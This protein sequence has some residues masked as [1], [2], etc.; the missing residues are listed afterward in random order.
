[1]TAIPAP[2]RIVRV[3]EEAGQGP[4]GLEGLDQPAAESCPG[5]VAVAV[6]VAAA[7]TVD[8]GAG[9]RRSYSVLFVDP[10]VDVVSQ[11]VSQ[12]AGPGWVGAVQVGGIGL[13]TETVPKPPSG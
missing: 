3:V 12:V 10:L 6:V 7:V 1:M 2:R 5:A 13:A 4:K 8:G 11:V 9:R